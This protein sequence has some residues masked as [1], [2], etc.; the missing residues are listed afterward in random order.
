MKNIALDILR[1]EAKEI[2]EAMIKETNYETRR[3][4]SRR[5]FI[6]SSKIQQMINKG[7]VK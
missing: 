4:L 6:L 2:R 3:E 5:L 7:E 1:D